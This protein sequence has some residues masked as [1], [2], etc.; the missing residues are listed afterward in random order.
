MFRTKEI[1]LFSMLLATVTIAAQKNEWQDPLV[2]QVNRAPMHTNYFAYENAE[3]AAV[4]QRTYSENFMSINGTWKF[5]LAPTPNDRP[6]N[7]FA[8]NFNDSQW[9]NMN[10]PGLFELSGYGNPIY[11]NTGYA[12]RNQFKS[13]PPEVPLQN[14]YVGSYRRELDI[15]AS[16]NGKTVMAHFG[17]VTSNMYLW[18]NGKYVGYSEDSKLEAEFDI[19]K[20]LKKGKNLIAFQIFRWCDGTYLEDQDFMRFTGVARDCYL[21]ARNTK[22][23]NDIR[24]ETRLDSEYKNADLIV[25]IDFSAASKGCTAELV[26]IDNAGKNI[27]TQ[28]LKSTGKTAQISIAVN[29]PDKWSAEIP[30]LYNLSVT[31]KD[32]N[33]VVETI[34]FKV[35]FRSV[36]IKNGQLL[37]NGKA[38]L[39]KGVNRH[40][41]DPVTGYIISEERMIADIKTIKSLNMNAV[42]TCHYPN[43]NRWYELCDQYGLYLVAEANIESHGMGYGEKTLAKRPDYAL[44]HMERD[45]R[46]VQRSRN[47]ASVIIWSLGNEAGNGD[48]FQKTYDWIK[49]N[50]TTRPVQYEQ[51]HDK[52]RNTDIYCPMYAG[53]NHSENYLKKNPAKPLI[54]CEYAHA[55]GNSMGGFKEYWELVR[56]YPSYQGGFIWDFADQS[57]REKNKDGVWIY[58]YGGDWN[59]YD[60]SDNNFMCNGVVA[61]DRSYN[62]H[63]YEVQYFYQNLWTT[64]TNKENGSIEVFNENFFKETNDIYLKWTLLA[65]GESVQSG[66]IDNI[67]I[68]PQEKGKYVLNYDLTKVCPSAEI[69]LNIEFVKKNA[70]Q[71]L[72]AGW[73]TARQQLQVRDMA[74]CCKPMQKAA[75]AAIAID[76]ADWKYLRISAGNIVMDF[77]KHNGYLCSYINNG[78]QLIQE[79][80]ALHPNFW[81]APTDNDF[82]ASLQRKYIAWKNPRLKLTKFNVMPNDDFAQITAEY[83]IEQIGGKLTLSY[84]IMPCG[85]I[86][87][88]QTL[89]TGDKKDVANMFRFGMQVSLIED[90]ENMEYYGHGPHENYID[91]NSSQFIGKYTQ[92]V[93]EQ[94]YPYIRPQETGN[95]SGL[96]YLTL[97]QQNGNGIKI[98]SKEPFEASALHHSIEMLDEGWDKDQRHGHE[99]AAEKL[100]SLCIDKKQMGMGCVNSWGAMPLSQYT[101]PYDNYDFEF[102]IQPVK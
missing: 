95:H 85:T 27:A 65:N 7:F 72:P 5:N 87:V 37:V 79:E 50:D 44:A 15:P 52:G 55:M 23:M 88:K 74:T 49:A 97:T 8:E 30:T 45:Q 57:L 53:Y 94:Y 34:P 24:L 40:E 26:L 91:R 71:L 16:W 70:E 58:T 64:L 41:L 12:W 1:A 19:T 29:N 28:E 54:Q 35:G 67:N 2:N 32:K 76:S 101:L 92:T 10:V 36:E 102:T 11:V 46:N 63:A 62:P 38:I 82:G 73:V 81:R 59:K 89:T 77:N 47:H 96:R 90:M 43:N 33:T 86:K 4:G 3:K 84:R 99:M 51:A 93:T 14:N 100:T 98:S 83:N 56:K 9:D 61:P 75:Q 13:N 25:D 68:K 17:S 6:A 21:Y 39:I 22:C 60:A 48:N 42:R 80:Y 78:T 20:Y 31:L 18:V 69:F 66:L